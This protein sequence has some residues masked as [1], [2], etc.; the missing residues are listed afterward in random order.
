MVSE[1]DDH[2]FELLLEERVEFQFSSV[3]LL[4]P[5]LRPHGL[6]HTRPPCPSPTPRVYS[7]S[8]PLSRWC[9]PTVYLIL[10]HPFYSHLQYFP[11]LGS[12]P[13]SRFFASGGQNI[14][15]SASASVLPVNIQDCSHL[16]WTG[17]ISLLSKWLSRVFNT[18]VQ[19]HQFFS[20]KLS[21]SF[22]SY[23]LLI[24]FLLK[25]N[26]FTE[27]CCFCQTSTWIKQRCTYIPCLLNLP[28]ISLP[29][30]PL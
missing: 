29:I 14:G 8:C 22:F 30:P 13:R 17:W 20:A 23:F 19:K 7:N 25:D 15:V 10:C 5:T 12:F 9:H 26:C 6:Q 16:G 18:T 3:T 27:F 21:F 1:Y 11:A 28:P 24:Y 4:C 2:N